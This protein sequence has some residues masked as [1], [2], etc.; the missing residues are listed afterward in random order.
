M[1]STSESVAAYQLGS[2]LLGAG[3]VLVW[4]DITEQGREQFYD[5]HDKEHIPERLAI[6]GFRR[7]RRY[8]TPRVFMK[9]VRHGPVWG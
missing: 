8:I 5:W 4:N 1:S 9:L 3:V 7:G 6:P 2:A